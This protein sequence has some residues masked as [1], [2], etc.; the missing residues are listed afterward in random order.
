VCVCVCVTRHANRLDKILERAIRNISV[1]LLSRP[2]WTRAD[3]QTG[4]ER[5]LLCRGEESSNETVAL[6]L[7][8]VQTLYPLRYRRLKSVSFNDSGAFLLS[9]LLNRKSN[10][11]INKG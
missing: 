9:I 8:D 2:D 10:K 7:L 3:E 6:A 5:F 4:D 11:Y 1:Q